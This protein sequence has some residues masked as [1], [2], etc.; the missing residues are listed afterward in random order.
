VAWWWSPY[1]WSREV[2]WEAASG[3]GSVYTFSVVHR[4]DLP[5]FAERLPYV[6]AVVELEEGPRVM[7][8]VVDVDP[9]E[10]WIE[11]PVAVDFASAGVDGTALVPVFRP[12]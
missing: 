7:T 5:G 1:C 4:N 8:N 6:A 12:A 11:M 3:R 10:V 2:R 9:A